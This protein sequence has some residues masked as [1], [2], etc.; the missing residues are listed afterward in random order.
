MNLPQAKPQPTYKRS[1]LLAEIILQ[2]R[3]RSASA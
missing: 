3:R 2:V 1:P